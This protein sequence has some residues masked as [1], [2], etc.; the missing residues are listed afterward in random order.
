MSAR[1]RDLI[2]TT[3]EQAL[4]ARARSLPTPRPTSSESARLARAVDAAL[5]QDGL[6]RR[7]AFSPAAVAAAVFCAAAASATGALWWST[8]NSTTT[9]QTTTNQP[10]TNQP[11]T[12][13]PTTET[14]TNSTTTP[15][16]PTT[17]EPPTAPPPTTLESPSL[18]TKKPKKKAPPTTWQQQAEQ[19]S[20][21][22]QTQQAASLVAAVL[23]DHDRG[24][25]DKKA[26]VV[27]FWGLA[28]RDPDVIDALAD[29]AAVFA[30]RA[31]DD[32]ARV[33]RLG[34]E[35]RLRYRRDATAVDGCRAFGQRF[36]GHPA[37]RALAFGAGGLAE[38]L[39]DLDGAIDEYTR[40]VVLAPLMGATGAEAL[41]ARARVRTRKGDLDEARADLRVYL[42]KDPRPAATRDDEVQGLARALGVSL[43]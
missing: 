19:L 3:D 8:T 9:N 16:P 28:G 35:L 40:A 7:R 12:N 41:L 15:Q 42:Q 10:T 24:D 43:P 2:L 33:L 37:A 38:E 18:P 17:L 27:T 29:D 22:G 32:V 13:Q 11:T 36:P 1:D 23:V 5:D 14:E 6:A 30:D 4:L 31:D 25:D 21:Q 39:G 26:A 20:A 34:C